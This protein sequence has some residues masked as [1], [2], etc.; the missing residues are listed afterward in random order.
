[1]RLVLPA[2][3]P[4]AGGP[5]DV[6]GQVLLALG[7]VGVLYGLSHSAS[8]LTDFLTLAPLVGGLVL[9]ALFFLRE[10][11]NPNRFFPVGLFKSPIFMA[12]ICAGFVYNF[13]T[14]VGFLQLTNLWQ[15]ING[16][17]TLEVSLW[18]LPFLVSGIVAA[19]VFGRLMTKGMSNGVAVMVGSASA[20]VG[21]ALL[22]IGHTSTSLAGFLPGC[23]L[24]GAG[25]IITSLPYGGLIMKQAP[26]KYF[27]PV[28]SSR[29]TI[30][31]FFYA[32]GLAL[33]T[34]VVDRITIGG[35]VGSLNTAGVPPTQTGQALDAVTAFASAGTQ[36]SAS[37]GQ[38]ALADAGTSYGTGFATVMIIAAALSLLVGTIG[39]LLLRRHEHVPAPTPRDAALVPL[40]P[41]AVHG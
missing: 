19:L 2:Q 21:F 14:A 41:P 7:V 40:I 10:S 37:L 22:A 1:M 5:A 36:P 27:G 4:V 24:V 39:F 8:G 32:A 29:T 38:Q 12:A 3:P 6:P 34:V 20:T 26:A 18:Q 9:L 25:L 17:T 31:Q 35:V 23:I 33:S 16:L 28:T 13:G 30:G 15:F 11:T